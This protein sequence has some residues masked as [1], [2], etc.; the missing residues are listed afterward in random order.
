MNADSLISAD[1][2]GPPIYRSGSNFCSTFLPLQFASHSSIDKC[3]RHILALG[4]SVC[5]LFQAF[6]YYLLPSWLCPCKYHRCLDHT[7]SGMETFNCITSEKLVIMVTLI[8]HGTLHKATWWVIALGIMGTCNILTW[9]LGAKYLFFC[10]IHWQNNARLEPSC[11]K[12][13]EMKQTPDNSISRTYTAWGHFCLSVVRRW[14]GGGA[15]E[16]RWVIYLAGTNDVWIPINNHQFHT[17][18]NWSMKG[19]IS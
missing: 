10:A 13:A 18:R 5:L 3:W 4:I 6:L 16:N 8:W 15:K 1:D 2:I 11:I 7:P 17:G 19:M 14:P 12:A 9:S